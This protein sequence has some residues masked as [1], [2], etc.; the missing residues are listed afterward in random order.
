MSKMPLLDGETLDFNHV[1]DANERVTDTVTLREDFAKEQLPWW[2]S[3]ETNNGPASPTFDGL[4]S[5]DT[6]EVTLD[7]GTTSQG[8][9]TNLVGPTLNWDNWQEIGIYLLN[10]SN[11]YEANDQWMQLLLADQGDIEDF[12]NGF[13]LRMG[14]N[15]YLM[16]TRNGG[17]GRFYRT[18]TFSPTEDD[19]HY[20]FR[21][22]D[23]GDGHTITSYQDGRPIDSQGEAESDFPPSSDLTIY[24]GVRTQDTGL[25]RGVT[26]DAVHI[27]LVPY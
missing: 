25:D 23:N 3:Y 11:R 27:E 16:R 6:T 15:T 20:G 19:H 10:A 7:T 13:G 18:D 1:A 8:D 21:F 9:V 24:A 22:R 5:G 26:F 12:S 14:S 4:A 17:S 2:L